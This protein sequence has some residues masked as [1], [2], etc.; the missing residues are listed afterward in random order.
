[1]K[2]MKTPKSAVWI[3]ASGLPRRRSPRPPPSLP[4]RARAHPP[5]EHRP[6]PLAARALRVGVGGRHPRVAE[7]DDARERAAAVVLRL[8]LGQEAAHRRR[9]EEHVHPAASS[10]WRICILPPPS[11]CATSLR[12]ESSR[13]SAP[14][15]E[16]APR[17]RRV[18]VVDRR[19]QHEERCGAR[20]RKSTP[21]ARAPSTCR[22]HLGEAAAWPRPPPRARRLRRAF[23]RR[24]RRSCSA[25][26][27]PSAF[28]ASSAFSAAAFSAARFSARRRRSFSP[29]AALEPPPPP[30]PAPSSRRAGAQPVVAD[31]APVAPERLAAPAQR[32]VARRDPALG[33]ELRLHRLHRRVGARPQ[34]DDLVGA[35]GGRR[36]DEELDDR[37]AVGRRRPP[38]ERR[39]AR[40]PSA[41]QRS[42]L[43]AA[44][45]ER[46]H[47][48]SSSACASSA[49]SRRRGAV[50]RVGP[51]LRHLQVR[52]LG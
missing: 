10:A 32:E 25:R 16:H 43:S 47:R 52:E 2:S 30:S 13:M 35:A 34:H 4:P 9:V 7:R 36:V 20:R 26:A 6:E 19:S 31:R 45:S 38:S 14:A 22:R 3:V 17:A 46:L 27:P 33:G 24:L 11:M 15:V 41:P 28:S 37:R 29:G 1:M 51:A 12:A 50:R 39:R 40:R 8:E 21:R 42:A 5:H 18:G 23:L 44:S 48:L 49:S